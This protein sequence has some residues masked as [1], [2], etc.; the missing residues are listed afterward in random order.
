M[1][2][3]PGDAAMRAAFAALVVALAPGLLPAQDVKYVGTDEFTGGA[4]AAEVGD[5]PLV[6]TGQVLPLDAQG[7]VLKGNATAQASYALAE[8]LSVIGGAG[9]DPEKVVRLNV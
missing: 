2:R 7:E 3:T 9:G 6:H 8:V 1:V 5:V 4:L